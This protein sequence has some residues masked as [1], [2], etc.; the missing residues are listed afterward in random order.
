M[1]LHDLRPALPAVLTSGFP[2]TAHRESGGTFEGRILLKPYTH[3]ELAN[4]IRSALDGT[5][6]DFPATGGRH[7]Q[8]VG[9]N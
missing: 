5:T 7:Y 1:Q 3:Q 2:D 8:V 4:V 6:G 9:Y